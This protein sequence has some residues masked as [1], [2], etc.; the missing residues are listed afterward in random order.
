V[1]TAAKL[2]ELGVIHEMPLQ[3]FIIIGDGAYNSFRQDGR[4]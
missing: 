4:F 3:D 2:Q 1:K